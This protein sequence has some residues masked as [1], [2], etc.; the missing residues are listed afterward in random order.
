MKA[1]AAA[2][3]LALGVLTANVADAQYVVYQ[4]SP[5]VVYYAPV[6]SSYYVP[7]QPYSTPVY[8]AYSVPAYPTPGYAAPAYAP[9]EPSFFGRLMDLERRKNAWLRQTF[10]GIP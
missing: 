8:G 1:L 5:P 7:A 10:L 9:A 4:S 2:V 3:V 6:Y